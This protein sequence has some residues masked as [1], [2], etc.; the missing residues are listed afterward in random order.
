[1]T[2]LAKHL[3]PLTGR[4]V[5]ALQV[6]ISRHK[7][8]VER[9]L[10]PRVKGKAIPIVYQGRQF[11]SRSALADYLA[12]LTGLTRWALLMSLCRYDGDVERVLARRRSPA[13]GG[14]ASS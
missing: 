13:S 2:A 4:S 12:P 9:M 7:G 5:T 3:A 11:R 14:S 8:D 10:Q 1:M 6:A